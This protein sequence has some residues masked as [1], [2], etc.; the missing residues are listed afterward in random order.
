MNGELSNFFACLPYGIS[1][2]FA[3]P[4][5]FEIHSV[6]YILPA[7]ENILILILISLILI[8]PRKLNINQQILIFYF[9]TFIVI[10]Y[11][12]LGLL[13]PVLGN[14]VRYKAP[15]LPFLFF[16]LLVLIDKSKISQFT[17]KNFQLFKPQFQK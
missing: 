2:G 17:Y 3:R 9:G 4:H 13:V 10:T 15:L 12:F 11:T 8:F 14:L 5:I 7:L 1:N 16:S 6:T